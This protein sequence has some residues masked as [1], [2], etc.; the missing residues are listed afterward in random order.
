MRGL[1]GQLLTCTHNLQPARFPRPMHASK[2]SPQSRHAR[3]HRQLHALLSVW[4]AQV[5]GNTLFVHG[6]V[7]SEALGF[8]PSQRM[9]YRH[10][11]SAADVAGYRMAA[12]RACGV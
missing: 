10:A 6:T 3:T 4:V 11:K 8:V 12:A 9:V 1:G 5:M 2:P 7:A